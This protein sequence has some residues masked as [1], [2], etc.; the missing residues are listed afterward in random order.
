MSTDISIK[1]KLC[2]A[3]RRP[4]EVDGVAGPLKRILNAIYNTTNSTIIPWPSIDNQHR[5]VIEAMGG[6]ELAEHLKMKLPAVL[7]ARIVI[8]F[9][10]PTDGAEPIDHQEAIAAI[11]QLID[12]MLEVKDN[13]NTKHLG[14]ASTYNAYGDDFL[15]GPLEP[16][17]DMDD[18]HYIA[19]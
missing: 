16:E 13:A 10:N 15:Q 6:D 9:T 2:P 1:A 18:L 5:L 3:E 12:E 8:E 11:D 4:T 17:Y 19:D 7:S 14:Q